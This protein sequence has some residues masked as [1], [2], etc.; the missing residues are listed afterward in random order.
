MKN[1]NYYEKEVRKQNAFTVHVQNFK[2]YKAFRP[3]WHDYYELLFFYDGNA[4]VYCNDTEATVNAGDLVIVNRAEVHTMVSHG[5]ASYYC[6][7]LYPEFFSDIDLDSIQFPNLIKDDK[8]AETLMRKLYTEVCAKQPGSDMLLKSYAYTLMAHLLRSYSVTHISEKESKILAQK[9]QRMDKVLDYIDKHY[10]EKLST[11]ALAEFC[12]LN[13]SYF[14]RS[15][16]KATGKSVLDY[17]TDYR[18]EKATIL[19]EQSSDSVA[20]IAAQVGFEDVTYFSRCFKKRKGVSPM[21]F[22]KH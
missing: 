19:L 3:H 6:V 21:Q 5:G 22:R 10:N 12:Y 18:I 11:H 14:C 17:L 16:K 9:A 4:K 2:Q 20:T 15:F 1:L 7:I 8:T 13:E